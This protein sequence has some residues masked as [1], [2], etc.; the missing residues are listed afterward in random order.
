MEQRYNE[1]KM[2][3]FVLKYCISFVCVE[4]F[5]T[6]ASLHS[7]FFW[8][9]KLHDKT[10]VSCYCCRCRIPECEG[11]ESTFNPD[12]LQNAVPFHEHDARSVPRRC[13]RFAFRNLSLLADDTE[14]NVSSC[15]PE[16]FDNHSV[17][18]CDEWVYA[19]EETT[20]LREVR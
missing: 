17:V 19:E 7:V 5:M 9:E 20:I 3:Y 4:Y 13:L 18:R 16:S 11:T 1:H 12:W 2:Q 14:R 10:Q 8:Q 6:L 15:S